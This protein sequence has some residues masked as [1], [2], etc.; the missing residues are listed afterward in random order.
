MQPT[1]EEIAGREL[2][3]IYSAA[4]F[5]SA[6]SR[7]L[8]EARVIGVMERAADRWF[9]GIAEDPGLWIEDCLVRSFLDD[10][11]SNG[12]AGSHR[13][14]GAAQTSARA[15]RFVTWLSEPLWSRLVTPARFLADLT[16]ERIY[17]AAGALPPDARAAIWL[18]Q[19]RRRSYAAAAETLHVEAE[20]LHR[21]LRY[22]DAF[23]AELIRLHGHRAH[24]TRGA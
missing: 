22:R 21:L 16:R 17:D 13:V 2:G 19:F 5:L 18:V 3:H 14:S 11:A 9:D 8:A 10:E 7:R 12:T 23:L 6:G 20:E 4:L 1:F 15:H 24:G